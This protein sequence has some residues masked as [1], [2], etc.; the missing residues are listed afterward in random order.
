M[1]VSKDAC[2]QSSNVCFDLGF[3]AKINAFMKPEVLNNGLKFKVLKILNF[4]SC[5]QK[6]H[7]FIEKC[8]KDRFSESP[9]FFSENECFENLSKTSKVMR[10]QRF[11]F[12]LI[13]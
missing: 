13:C 12:F 3:I 2:Y 6:A 5:S 8:R 7:D 11:A 9:I 10:F 1:N 4:T